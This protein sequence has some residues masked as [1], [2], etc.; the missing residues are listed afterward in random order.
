MKLI[1]ANP[2][3]VACSRCGVDSL[4]TTAIVGIGTGE[5]KILHPACATEEHQFLIAGQ[6]RQISVSAFIN[7]LTTAV[8][9]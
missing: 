9:L 1:A 7:E 5:V 8:G 2:V 4:D 6:A 3:R